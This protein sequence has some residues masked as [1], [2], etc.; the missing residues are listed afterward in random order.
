MSTPRLTKKFTIGKMRLHLGE[1][2]LRLGEALCLSGDSLLLG[3]LEGFK[4]GGLRVC[5]S[6]GRHLGEPK[7][8]S[9]G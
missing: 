2:N 6:E 1:G 9:V 8:C 3:E 5:L 4:N 7:R